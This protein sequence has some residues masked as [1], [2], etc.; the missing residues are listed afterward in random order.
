[1]SVSIPLY[2]KMQVAYLPILP[3]I[4]MPAYGAYSAVMCVG[5]SSAGLLLLWISRLFRP[6]AA[7][8]PQI[9]NKGNLS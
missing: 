4:N 6:N 8:K 9:K 3:D 5:W 2:T 7:I 1:M